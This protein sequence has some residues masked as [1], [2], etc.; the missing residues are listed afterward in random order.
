MK[1][2][3]EKIKEK[4]ESVLKNQ[5]KLFPME[6]GVYMMKDLSGKVLYVG[7]ATSL[8]DRVSSYFQAYKKIH[9]IRALLDQTDHIEFII[10]QTPYEALIL[11]CNFIKKYSPYYNVMLKDS[12][13]YLYLK[14]TNHEFP[15]IARVRTVHHDKAYYFGPYTSA[16]AANALYKLIGRTFQIRNCKGD[17]KPLKRPCLSY[18]L[19]QCSAPCIEHITHDAYLKRVQEAILFLKQDYKPL[20]NYITQE[21]NR[22]AEEE[23]F[24]MAAYMRDQLFGID[25][26]IKKQR[27]IYSKPYQQDIWSV[28]KVENLACVELMKIRDGK[29]IFEDSFF[30]EQDYEVSEPELLRQFL[31]QYY[32]ELSRDV[33]PKEILL[34]QPIEDTKELTT[35][36]KEKFFLKKLDVIVPRSGDRKQ[37]VNL[38]LE[39][40][41]KHFDLHFQ[42]HFSISPSTISPLLLKVQEKLQLP[43]IPVRMEGYDISNISGVNAVGSMVVFINGKPAPNQYRIFKIRHTPGPNDFA[44]IQEVISRRIKHRDK[45]FGELPDVFVIDG[46]PIQLKFA[47]EALEEVNILIPVISLAKKEELI[48][49]NE[50]DEPIRLEQHSDILQLLQ[51]IRDESHRFAKKHFTKLHR[52]AAL[53][54]SNQKKSD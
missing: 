54:G 45:K 23:N 8:R 53:S 46:G 38:A 44:M 11:E 27:V 31:I 36:M 42:G 43:S 37:V 33:P 35:W 17:V 6:P 13:N 4:K 10:T 34:S 52:K 26:M 14:I 20:K 19:Q 32:F 1:L 3:K 24:E 2:K 49:L 48:Y 12:K 16:K 18:F 5:V 7:K 28:F 39:N 30:H 22:Y 41:K 21:M 25:E 15:A 51:R 40:A 9:K 29:I 47:R 50:K